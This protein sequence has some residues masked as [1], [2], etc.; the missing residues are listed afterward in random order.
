MFSF[1]F[2][3]V[4]VLFFLKRVYF[5]SNFNFWENNEYEHPVSKMQRVGKYGLD[6]SKIFQRIALFARIEAG[7]LQLLVVVR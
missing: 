5:I 7:I 4:S 3:N 1:G 2:I 6:L